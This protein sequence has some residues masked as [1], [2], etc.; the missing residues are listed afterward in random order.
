MSTTV[1]VH[2]PETEGGA[3][4]PED[5]REEREGDISLPFLAGA[6]SSNITYSRTS[7]SHLLLFLPY[8]D[9]N[10]GSRLWR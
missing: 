1:T 3:S 10:I 2:D 6:A 9:I 5:G 8:H 4:E 7:V